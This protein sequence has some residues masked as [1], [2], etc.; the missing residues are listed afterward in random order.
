MADIRDVRSFDY[1]NHPY[2]AVREVLTSDAGA[3]FREATRAATDRARSVA[4]E[5]RV[6]IGGIDVAKE[7]EISVD[8]VEDVER[9]PTSGP[10][11]R[12]HLSWEAAEKP[13]LFP[14]M[15]A[16]LSVYPLTSTETQLDFSG[17][18]EPPLGPLGKAI[19]AALGHR[20][21]EA[22]VHRF[23]RDVAHHLRETL[24]STASA[25]TA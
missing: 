13:G 19:D 22:S 20:I 6:R 23:V 10:A 3:V 11:T 21:A 16:I 25:P 9:G 2:D 17:R 14:F 1:V 24:G 4:S 5:L 18:Y 15:H 12:I 7:I 8:R